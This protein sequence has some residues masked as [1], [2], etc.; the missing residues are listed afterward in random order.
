[1]P[2]PKM[3]PQR[4][5]RIVYAWIYERVTPTLAPFEDPIVTEQ[6]EKIVAEIRAKSQ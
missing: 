4:A 5:R 6:Y 3:N 2:Q 1:M